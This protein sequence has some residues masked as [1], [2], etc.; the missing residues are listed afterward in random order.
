MKVVHG[1]DQTSY[2]N[3]G[4]RNSVLCDRCRKPHIETF[5]SFYHCPQC[6]FD[7]CN[8]CV[9][10]HMEDRLSGDA[11]GRVLGD[12]PWLEAC[13]QE[14]VAT[15]S[16][17]R[18]AEEQRL[19]EQTLN[20]FQQQYIEHMIDFMCD[21]SVT[22][23]LEQIQLLEE[24]KADIAVQLAEE[25]ILEEFLREWLFSDKEIADLVKPF[26]P[27]LPLEHSTTYLGGGEVKKDAETE[28]DESISGFA[29]EE[30]VGMYKKLI[31]SPPRKQN[32]RMQTSTEAYSESMEETQREFQ[33]SMVLQQQ[34]WMDRIEARQP[35]KTTAEIVCVIKHELMDKQK[36]IDELMQDLRTRDQ[37]RNPPSLSVSPSCASIPRLSKCVQRIYGN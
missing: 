15:L 32:R 17:E 2:M 14:A 28:P 19:V 7:L 11:A 31:P 4:E 30:I 16:R 8:A 27:E 22:S 20:I 6:Q 3:N 33:R 25:R 37:V 34:E 36:I 18:A 29:P 24:Q 21:Y 13:L 23:H 12:D 10:G 5:V 26:L 1:L 35:P 9:G